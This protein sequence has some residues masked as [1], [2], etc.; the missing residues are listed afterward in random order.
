MYAITKSDM[1]RKIINE[2]HD[3][4]P[5]NIT[6][7]DIQV[8]KSIMFVYRRFCNAILAL[9]CYNLTSVTWTLTILIQIINYHTPNCASFVTLYHVFDEIKC[10]WWNKNIWLRAEYSSKDNQKRHEIYQWLFFARK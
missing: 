9:K 7:D 6:S 3:V 8:I 1:V 2:M 10:F 5:G 4:C